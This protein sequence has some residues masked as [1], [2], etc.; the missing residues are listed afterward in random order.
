MTSALHMCQHSTPGGEQIAA[1][2]AAAPKR[3]WCTGKVEC[4]VCGKEHIS[5]WPDDIDDEDSME[6][7]YCGREACRPVESN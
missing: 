5:V 2:F 3:M 4:N 7:P 6:C 1:I